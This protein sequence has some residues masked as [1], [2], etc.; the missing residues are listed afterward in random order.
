MEPFPQIIEKA[1]CHT[2]WAMGPNQVALCL[3]GAALSQSALGSVAAG[4]GMAETDGKARL[5][6]AEPKRCLPPSLL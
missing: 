4:T 5:P 6:G 1:A 2:L 3:G